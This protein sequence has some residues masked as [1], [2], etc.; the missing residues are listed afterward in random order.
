[1]VR[2]VECFGRDEEFGTEV[3]YAVMSIEHGVEES[4]ARGSREVALCRLITSTTKFSQQR[5]NVVACLLVFGA[6]LL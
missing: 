5:S 6:P 4:G 3:Q 1:M 2:G